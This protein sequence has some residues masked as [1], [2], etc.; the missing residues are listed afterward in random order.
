P[1]LLP[2][3][4]TPGSTPPVASLT[5]PAIPASCARAVPTRSSRPATAPI[6]T[7]LALAIGASFRF[8]RSRTLL[9]LGSGINVNRWSVCSREPEAE[10]GRNDAYLSATTAGASEAAAS[11]AATS[12]PAREWPI[13]TGSFRLQ[14][15]TAEILRIVGAA[16]ALVHGDLWKRT[17]GTR[18]VD[19]PVSSA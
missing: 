5:T 4:V 14:C 9:L 6:P 10:E 7:A 1:G 11:A 2:V 18:A 16:R 12:G 19:L 15:S 17:E 13:M 3:T 8:S